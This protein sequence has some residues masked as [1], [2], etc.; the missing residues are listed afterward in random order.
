MTENKGECGGNGLHF[1]SGRSW[2]TEPG[3]ECER[4]KMRD[5]LVVLSACGGDNTLV[6]VVMVA[7]VQVMLIMPIH[8]LQRLH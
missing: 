4:E 2:E 3:K 1:K 7:E 8:L 6:T 5:S